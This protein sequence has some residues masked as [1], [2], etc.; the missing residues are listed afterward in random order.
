M[1]PCLQ[2]GPLFRPGPRALFLL[3]LAAMLTARPALAGPLTNLSPEQLCP[4]ATQFE[5]LPPPPGASPLRP[6]P[7]PDPLGRDYRHRLQATAHGWPT[8]A[9]WCIWIE[10]LSQ[11]AAAGRWEQAWLESLQRALASWGELVAFS[12]VQD[13]DRA[14]L[15]ILRRRPPLRG[16]RASHGRAELSLVRVQRQGSSWQQEPRV[17]LSLSPGQR[18]AAMQA[19]ALHELGHAFGLWGHSDEP[20]D[21]MAAV[22]GAVPVLE[23]SA[24]DRATLRWL[25]RQPGLN[26]P[27]ASQQGRPEPF[28]TES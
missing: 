1:L 26:P 8:R 15:Q 5:P 21:A 25:Q 18:P 20:G 2:E 27:A 9:H 13:P 19:T 24:R 3:A 4:L 28:R 23:L 17:Q 6:S 14:Q 7:A 16:G 11:Q 12:V 22:P 10:P